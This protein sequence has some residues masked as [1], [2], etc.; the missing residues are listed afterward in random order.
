MRRA[1]SAASICFFE[2]RRETVAPAESAGLKL[3]SPAADKPDMKK[4]RL[5]SRDMHDAF[6]AAGETL[7]LICRLRGINASDLPPDEVDAFWN[8]ALDVA[9]QKDLVPDE[10][11]RN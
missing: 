5:S 11:R 7:A 9:A 2:A 3:C 1:A 8:M 4:K 6:A 10:A